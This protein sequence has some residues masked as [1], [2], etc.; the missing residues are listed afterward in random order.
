MEETP[1]DIKSRFLSLPDVKKEFEHLE[2]VQGEAQKRV[3]WET[4]HNEEVLRAISIVERFLRKKHR[5]CYGGQAINMLLPAKNRFYDS[6]YVIPDY[7]FFVP[8]LRQDADDLIKMLQEEGFTDVNYRIGIHDGTLKINVNYVPVADM[9]EMNPDVFAILSKRAHKVDGISYCD[10][11]FLRMLMHLE[12]SRPRGQVDRW[13]KVYERLLLL[14]RAYPVGTCDDPLR[15]KKGVPSEDRRIILEFC[16]ASKRPLA[17]IEAI[18]ILDK[19]KGY[20]GMDTLIKIGGPCI[21][22]ST[23]AQVDAEDIR[24]RLPQNKSIRIVNLPALTDDLLSYVA[25]YRGNRPLALL[26]QEVACHA[27]TNL[28]LDTGEEMRIAMHDTMMQLY[29]ALMLFG[30]EEKKFFAMSLDC[31]LKKLYHITKHARREPSK[32]VPAFGLRCSGRQQGI[33]TL[34]KA[35]QL[36]TEEEKKKQKKGHDTRKKKN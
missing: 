8:T 6:R 17:G 1:K 22:F 30:R 32:F 36:R 9:T 2:H 4:A 11:E 20:I 15:V 12:L 5:I 26:V 34:R 16:V 21:L 31:I 10:P 3:D 18:G 24:D 27:Y 23:N 13:K 25:M 35:K 28:R 19:H 33:A 14:N 29:Y 7:D